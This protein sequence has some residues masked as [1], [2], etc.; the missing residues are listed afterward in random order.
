MN[1]FSGKIWV[2]IYTL[3]LLILFGCT[4][5]RPSA[6]S[7]GENVGSGHNVDSLQSVIQQQGEKIA[8]IEKDLIKYFKK[9]LFDDELV[10]CMGAGSISTWIRDIST[11][12]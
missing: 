9:N 12:L 4:G 3:I 2:I 8:S 10:V 5:I 7:K 1:A 6:Y 11:K